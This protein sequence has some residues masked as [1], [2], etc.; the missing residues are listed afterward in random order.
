MKWLLVA[1]QPIASE[2]ISPDRAI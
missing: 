2:E 1:Y